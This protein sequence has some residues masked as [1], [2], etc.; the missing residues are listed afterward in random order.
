[1]KMPMFTTCITM[2][3]I[4]YVLLLLVS[5]SFAKEFSSPAA[6]ASFR[7][8]GDIRS[9]S[10]DKELAIQILKGKKG[11]TY[12]ARSA[13]CST[14]CSTSC[15]TTCSTSC[16]TRC[17]SAPINIVIPD[18]PARKTSSVT[19]TNVTPRTRETSS[20]LEKKE[21]TTEKKDIYWD[22]LTKNVVH[23]MS[24][25]SFAQGDGKPRLKSKL[26]DCT[27]CGGQSKRPYATG[28]VKILDTDAEED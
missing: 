17:N 1:M 3:R 20:G 4:L 10:T 27:T 18:R 16:S 9:L 22:D 11:M 8:E 19:Q 25:K 13:G 28:A 6:E 23:N 26:P 5:C 12:G 21:A 24:C 15:S 2:N 14:R 7:R